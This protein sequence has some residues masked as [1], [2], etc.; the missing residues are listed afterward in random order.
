MPSEKGYL[1]LHNLLWSERK[2][3]NVALMV[4]EKYPAALRHQQNKLFQLPLHVE[5]GNQCRP[6]IVSKCIELYPESL[7]M[8]D[9]RGYLPFHASLDP[10][11]SNARRASS[12]LHLL[13]AAHPT[14]F[15]YPPHDPVIDKLDAIKS[16]DLRRKIFN[17]HPSCLSSIAHVQSYHDLNWQSRFSLLQLWLQIM[18]K[19][20][21]DKL[22]DVDVAVH[23]G[24][25]KM[26]QFLFKLIKLCSYRHG[27]IEENQTNCHVL[28]EESVSI[29]ETDSYMI[30]DGDDL[31]DHQLRC[32]IAFT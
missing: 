32:I 15:Y 9:S 6:A 10:Q 16:P 31:G 11:R 20:Q 24:D 21:G 27:K 19:K 26:F 1:P 2:S 22:C 23:S 25:N 5:C 28:S 13:L 12:I 14:A 4:I 3:N 30:C 18:G 29:L 17:L 8:A 7:V